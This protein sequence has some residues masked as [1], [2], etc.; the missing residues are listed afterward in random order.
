MIDVMVPVSGEAGSARNHKPHIRV[1][2]KHMVVNTVVS[3]SLVLVVS[4]VLADVL[5][6]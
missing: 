1:D 2:V 4:D 5:T 6:C 3:G